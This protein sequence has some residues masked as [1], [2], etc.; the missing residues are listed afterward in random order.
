MGPGPW[1]P[2][3]GPPGPIIGPRGPPIIGGPMLGPIFGPILGGPIPGPIGPPMPGPIGPLGPTGPCGPETKKHTIF[4][5]RSLRTKKSRI[6]DEGFRANNWTAARNEKTSNDKKTGELFMN[7]KRVRLLNHKKNKLLLE[8][9][10]NRRPFQLLKSHN[11]HGENKRKIA[12][13]GISMQQLTTNVIGPLHECKK[14]CPWMQESGDHTIG[15][16]NDWA[17]TRLSPHTIVPRHDCAHTRLCPDTFCAQTRLCPHMF[18]PRHYCALTCLC[19]YTFVPTHVC[20][21][22]RLCPYTFVPTHVCTQIV[23]SQSFLGRNVYVCVQTCYNK[24]T[25]YSSRNTACDCLTVVKYHIS[26]R[27]A[28]NSWTC[29]CL[30]FHQLIL[31]TQSL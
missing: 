29:T 26:L 22:T 8:V 16:I 31:W 30:C 7:T 1:G 9:G 19:P 12:Q 14:V 21:H 10:F 11:R 17:H 24:I 6:K 28:N 5:F 18:V 4:H 20:A 2:I 25:K 23:W 3:I 13:E 15:P 27:F